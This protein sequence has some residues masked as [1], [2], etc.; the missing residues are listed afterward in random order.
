[1]KS[2]ATSST[3]SVTGLA[4]A[5]AT[6]VLLSERFAGAIPP[7][8]LPVLRAGS[9]VVAASDVPASLCAELGLAPAPDTARLVGDPGAVLV[10]MSLD[11][12]AA[13]ALRRSGCTVI[14]APEPDGS[15][16]LDAAAVMDRLRSP[17][18]CPWD[19]EQTHES[20]RQYLVEETYELLEALDDGDRR[21]LR[22]E[23]GD[24]LLQV[25]FHARIAQEHET[26]PFDI[27]DVANDLVGKLVGRHPHVFHGHDPAVSDARSQEHR[28]EELKQQEKQRE[29]TVDG[30]PLAQPAAA[31]AAKLVQRTRRA[32]FPAELLPA[33][34]DIARSGAVEPGLAEAQG[35]RLF[36]AVAEAK[37]AGVDPEGALRAAA[38]RF[39]AAVR[40]A[41]RAARDAGVDLATA[42]PDEWRRYWPESLDQR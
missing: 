12:P 20:L 38:R 10:A 4:S 7:G 39:A 17:G 25:L 8:A 42:G 13:D 27:S 6:V 30:V 16:L 22:E 15:G 34:A 11:D 3:S 19:A 5:S 23:L 35:D 9:A 14:A 21:S 36:A 32:G 2:D 18:G 37:L 24:V 28:W 26:D 31:L 33:A 40:A 41:E 1:M 29:S